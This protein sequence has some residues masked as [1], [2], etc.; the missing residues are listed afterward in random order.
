MLYV[1]QMH[2]IFMV[3]DS[4]ASHHKCIETSILNDEPKLF[5]LFFLLFHDCLL[6]VSIGFVLCIA[7]EMLSMNKRSMLYTNGDIFVNNMFF[8]QNCHT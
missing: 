2:L 5:R 8:F 4:I 6:I 3:A 7:K 1:F